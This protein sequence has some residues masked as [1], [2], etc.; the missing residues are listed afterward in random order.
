MVPPLV[1]QIPRFARAMVAIG[2][3]RAAEVAEAAT[4]GVE[5]AEAVGDRGS[6]KSEEA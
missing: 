1:S 6:L 3:A 4:A 5:A 2:E